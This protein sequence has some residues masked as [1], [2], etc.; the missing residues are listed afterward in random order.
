MAMVVYNIALWGHLMVIGEE[1]KHLLHVLNG[2]AVLLLILQ[3]MVVFG[4]DS[5]NESIGNGPEKGSVEVC[6]LSSHNVGCRVGVVE[7]GL[8]MG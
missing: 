6:L 8:F 3:I 5:G 1:L 4:P 7:V 2:G